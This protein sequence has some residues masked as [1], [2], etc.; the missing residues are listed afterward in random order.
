[1]RGRRGGEAG[2]DFDFYAHAR[3][4]EAGYEH[5]GGGG[6]GGEARAQDGPAGG[7]VFA[8]G[9]DVADTYDVGEG[10]AGFGEGRADGAQRL[11]RLGGRVVGDRHGR[12]VETRRAG[13][14]HE[15]AAHHGAGIADVALE[16]R[17]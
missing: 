4:G 12:I 7:E 6:C 16:R 13:D 5:G 14:E 9:E 17:A 10:G 15:L 1:M 8:A 2:R 3:V 11:C